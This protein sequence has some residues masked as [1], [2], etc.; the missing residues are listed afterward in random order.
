MAFQLK[1]F[2]SLCASMINWMKATQG[3]ITDFSVGSVARTLV[4]APAVEIEELYQ[5]YFI[6]LREAI[7]VATFLSFGFGRLPAAY[8]HGV[9]TVTRI[10]P[11]EEPLTIPVGTVFKAVDGRTY[12]SAE[13][14]TW[15]IEDLAIQVPVIAD[16]IG[17]HWNTSAGTITSSDF[18]SSLPVTI[19]NLPIIT[20]RDQETDAELEVRFAEFI[21]SL[22]RGTEAAVRYAVQ[23]A[24]VL[25]TEGTVSEYVVRVGFTEYG[26]RVWL[27]IYSSAGVPSIELLD[28]G[29]RI[30][31][32]YIDS[33]TGVVIPG[34]R[35]AG[36]RVDVLP[37]IERIVTSTVYV[38]MFPGYTLDSMVRNTMTDIFH[39]VVRSVESGSVLYINYLVEQLL[40]VP[41][42]R[43]VVIDNDENILCSVNEVLIPGEFEVDPIDE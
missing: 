40:T 16:Q 7:P 6:G 26:G 43:R 13:P 11:A 36:V 28:K 5:Q 14:I 2:P 3:R 19:S 30:I 27:Y 29:Q 23:Q 21:Q 39:D 33:D 34:Y 42:V 35:A 10:E 4:E 1:D 32:G 20:G 17:A 38:G 12:S 8:G 41:G 31:D 24:Q 15:P 22:S 37:M 18:F 25:T 9:V